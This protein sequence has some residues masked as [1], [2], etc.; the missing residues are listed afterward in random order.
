MGS[1]GVHSVGGPPPFHRW[2]GLAPGMLQRIL[3]AEPEPDLSEEGPP[4]AGY[5]RIRSIWRSR[6]SIFVGRSNA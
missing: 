1:E 4:Y 6:S 2:R 3:I 5:R